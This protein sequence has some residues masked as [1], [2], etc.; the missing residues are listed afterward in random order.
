MKTA[1]ADCEKEKLSKGQDFPAMQEAV[2]QS[3]KWTWLPTSLDMSA[4][5][6][7]SFDLIDFIISKWS[8]AK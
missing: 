8:S 2:P 6:Y 1:S 7:L 5:S 4:G 3:P